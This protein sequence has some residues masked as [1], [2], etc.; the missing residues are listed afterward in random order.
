MV[1]LD[2]VM[3]TFKEIH[4]MIES[5]IRTEDEIWRDRES[6]NMIMSVRVYV[7]E[8]LSDI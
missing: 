5:E 2:F 6:R 3:E 7:D 4:I 1:V 8:M